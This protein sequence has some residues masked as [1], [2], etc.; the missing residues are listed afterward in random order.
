MALNIHSD[1][2]AVNKLK[3]ISN[4]KI[5]STVKIANNLERFWV[6]IIELNDSYILGK[7]DNYLTFNSEY[8]Y[9]DIV[10]F[11]KENILDIHN[12]A[13]SQI[14]DRHFDTKCKVKDIK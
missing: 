14:L 5:G 11:E 6:K 3:I 13:I 10:I 7:I 9:E 8:D 1:D 2:W 4:L 12:I